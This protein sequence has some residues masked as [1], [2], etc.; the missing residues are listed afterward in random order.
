[1]VALEGGGIDAVGVIVVAYDIEVTAHDATEGF[2]FDGN[3]LKSGADE[4]VI[5]VMLAVDAL[6]LGEVGLEEVSDEV[7]HIG[8]RGIRRDGQTHV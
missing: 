6:D 7:F 8:L 1:M 5:F 2:V 3:G 4:E